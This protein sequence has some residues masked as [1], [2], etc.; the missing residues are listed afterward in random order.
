VN[1]GNQHDFIK[2]KSCLTT[3]LAFCDEVAVLVDKGKATDI[4]IYLTAQRSC[5]YPNPG[6][7]QG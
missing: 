5:G 2:G 6:N 7:V 3:L 4:I 1:G